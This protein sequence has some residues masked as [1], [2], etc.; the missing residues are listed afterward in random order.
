M[1]NENQIPEERLEHLRVRDSQLVRMIESLDA[2]IKSQEWR[3]LKEDLFDGVLDSIDKRVRQEN[4]KPELSLPELYRLQGEKRWAKK[5][6]RLE[7]LRESLH[8]ELIKIRKITI[9]PGD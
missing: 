1:E 8:Q 5:F 4:E 9:T 3:T 2:L 6:S 7:L